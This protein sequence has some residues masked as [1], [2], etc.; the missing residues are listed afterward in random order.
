[1]KHTQTQRLWVLVFEWEHNIEDELYVQA[2]YS[3]SVNPAE[4][5]RPI[6]PHFTFW[7]HFVAS[8]RASPFS[9]FFL[10][11][12]WEKSTQ[13]SLYSEWVSNKGWKNLFFVHYS[14]FNYIKKRF[15]FNYSS[16]SEYMFIRVM[17]W[18]MF[19]VERVRGGVTEKMF[20]IHYPSTENLDCI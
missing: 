11:V 15:Q 20:T 9:S 1:L 17:T 6:R 4:E 13:Q 18:T 16:E 3:K 10:E 8:H 7:F 12:H 14:Q 19:I 5:N 2:F